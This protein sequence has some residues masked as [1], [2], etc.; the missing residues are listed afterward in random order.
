MDIIKQEQ[1]NIK[2]NKGIEKMFCNTW[3]WFN[4][5]RNCTLNGSHLG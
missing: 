1:E 3:E 4:A 2:K 5:T